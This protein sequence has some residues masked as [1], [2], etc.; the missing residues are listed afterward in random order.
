MTG[1]TSAPRSLST[2]AVSRRGLLAGAAT[3]GGSSLLTSCIGSAGTTDPQGGNASTT[4]LTL[5]MGFTDAKARD[6]VIKV[7]G[8]YTGPKVTVN[9]IATEQLRAQLSTYLTSSQPPDVIAWLAGSVARAYARDGL[10]LDVSDLW[11]GDKAC[12]H[13]SDALKQLCS[14]DK[15]KQIFVP[16]SYY[17]WS[18]FYKKS[19]FKKWGIEPPTD[20]EAFIKMCDKLK[21]MGVNPLA[22]GIGSTPW[23][24]SGWFDYLDLRVNGAKFHRALLAGEE[25]FSDAKVVKVMEQYKRILPY[26]DKNQTSYSVQEAVTPWVQDKDAMYLV[27]AFITASVPKQQQDDIDFFSVPTIDSTVPSAEEAPTDG[28]FAPAGGKHAG[29]T[30]DFLNYLAGPPAQ[31]RNIELSGSSNLPTSGDVD[32]SKFSPLVQKGIKLLQDTKEITQFFNRDSSDD[33]QLTADSALTKFIDDPSAI[34]A[35]LKSW[36]AEAQKVFKKK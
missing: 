31:Q 22:N 26:F 15:G 5:S 35:S 25:S 2:H 24:A 29:A 19:A 23:M 1:S 34:P 36:Q 4:E 33:L 7:S 13:F 3:V 18:I 28:Y 27:G 11:K 14:D 16:T 6:A 32:T 17:W 12:A 20:W 21:G 10:L 9:A 30:K 8:E